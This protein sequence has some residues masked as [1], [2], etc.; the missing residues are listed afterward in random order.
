M[1]DI[2]LI[3]KEYQFIYR[4]SAIIYNK[5]KNKILLFRG[6]DRDFYML[7]GGK[8]HYNE[9]SLK[10]IEREIEEEIGYTN[11]HYKLKAV[12]EEFTNAKGYNN[13]QISLIFETVNENI[14]NYDDFKSKETDWINFKWINIDELNKYIIY[15]KKIIN[16]I[17]NDFSHLIDKTNSN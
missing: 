9:T 14:N 12:A 1:N 7:P 10:A 8:V 2:K 17:E 15:P 11:L 6:N 3:D 13:H 16:I 4:V 5:E